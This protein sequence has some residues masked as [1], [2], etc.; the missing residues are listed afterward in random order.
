MV[1]KVVVVVDVIK[2]LNQ[3][4]TP[5]SS[6]KMKFALRAGIFWRKQFSQFNRSCIWLCIYHKRVDS[7]D[8]QQLFSH[9]SHILKKKNIS[10]IRPGLKLQKNGSHI[11]KKYISTDLV[12]NCNKK[13][14]HIFREKIYI[15]TDLFEIA[16]KRWSIYFEKIYI[17]QSTWF[18]SAIKIWFTSLDQQYGLEQTFDTLAMSVQFRNFSFPL[19]VLFWQKKSDKNQV[20]TMACP[21]LHWIVETRMIRP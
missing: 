2:I 16:I 11:L 10:F 9:T 7:R 15:S 14:V 12:W 17:F 20:V 6:L 4:N 19:Y 21:K 5:T 8:L 3:N 13:M 1:C 18:E